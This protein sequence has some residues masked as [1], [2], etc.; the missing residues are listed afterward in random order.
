MNSSTMTMSS[1]A[2]PPMSGSES[3]FLVALSESTVLS[4]TADAR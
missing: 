3:G 2:I 4:S 1:P